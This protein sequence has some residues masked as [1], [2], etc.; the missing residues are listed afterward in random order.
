MI[1]SMK[2]TRNPD[3]YVVQVPDDVVAALGLHEGD[4]VRVVKSGLV[5]ISATEEERRWALDTIK[6]LAKNNPLPPGYKFD[7][8]EAN[9]R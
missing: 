6:E 2:L 4:S 8:D 5:T 3:G 1:E 7:R 9:A